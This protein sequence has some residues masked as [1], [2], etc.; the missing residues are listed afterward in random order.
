M[1][2]EARE[3]KQHRREQLTD[4]AAAHIS[5]SA[6]TARPKIVL[7]DSEITPSAPEA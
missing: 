2:L 5:F 7:S 4:S 6:T 1:S 3:M